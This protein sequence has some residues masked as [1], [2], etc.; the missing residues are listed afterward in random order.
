MRCGEARLNS[1][2]GNYRVSIDC[3]K[4]HKDSCQDTNAINVIMAN[5]NEQVG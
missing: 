2:I 3:R 5:I 4:V 1:I